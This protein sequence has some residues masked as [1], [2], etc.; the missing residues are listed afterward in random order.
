MRPGPLQFCHLGSYGMPGVIRRSCSSPVRF[1][2]R[3]KMLACYFG[4]VHVQVDESRLLNKIKKT[5]KREKPKY[6]LRYRQKINSDDALGAY[7][8]SL[9]F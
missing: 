7:M 6:D 2:H 4:F 5:D 1:A 3:A 9:E 8:R